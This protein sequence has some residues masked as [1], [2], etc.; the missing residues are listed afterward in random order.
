MNVNKK[1]DRFKQWAGERMG[2]EVK[3]NLSENFKLLEEEMAC[4]H[5]G[6][7]R[8]Q[9]S[10]TTYVKS[11]SKT[12]EVE[13]KDRR[14]PVA[15]LGTTMLQH[16]EQMDQDSIFG[17]CLTD[18]GR[19]H[20]R[21]GR[22]QEGYIVKAT[23]SWLES[24]ERSLV[25]MKEYQAAR[26][27]LETR[28]LAY[29]T[30]LS[31]MQKAK[32]ED[33]RVEEELRAQKVKYEESNDDV[34]RRMQEIKESEPESV[35]DLKAFLD[36]ELEYHDRCGE[37]LRKLKQDWIA[38]D[39]PSADAEHRRSDSGRGRGR[40]ALGTPYDEYPPEPA[41]RSMIRSHPSTRAYH[42]SSRAVPAVPGLM[43]VCS[44]PVPD[45]DPVRARP[46][47]L[48]RTPTDPGAG[49]DRPASS[50]RPAPRIRTTRDL[51]HDASEDSAISTS[52]ADRS[53]HEPP[54]SPTTSHDGSVS[55]RRAPFEPPARPI[56]PAEAAVAGAKKV[57]PPPPP[58]RAKKPAPP[59]PPMKRSVLSAQLRRP[60][61]EARSIE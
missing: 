48:A 53:I 34:C 23:G 50:R 19:A 38:P 43:R 47:R 35:A 2:G 11:I 9:K 30:S 58:S 28:R 37:V 7:E 41:P 52:S 40:A 44:R 39:E 17:G 29:D 31:K 61:L 27:K 51:V 45:P 14:L 21:M 8:L 25:Q 36:A 20:Q 6:M 42:D 46:A 54:E 5:E 26:K 16:G 55:S 33:F 49:L 15:Y 57:P 13:D 18:M 56:S 24:L 60:G 1:F 10:M 59:P 12:K 3:T 22:I 32:R 4:R